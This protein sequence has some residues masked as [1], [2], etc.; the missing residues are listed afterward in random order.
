MIKLCPRCGK[1]F[2]VDNDCGDVIHQCNSGNAALDQ[3]DVVVIGNWQDSDGSSGT[4]G[5]HEVL[6]QGAENKLFG[7]FAGNEGEDV[8]DHTRR[9]ERASTHRSRQHFE[10]IDFK[11]V[12]E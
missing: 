4:K 1:H 2:V 6:M 12:N 8:E 10:F 5:S 11:E 9:G 7:T 3:E